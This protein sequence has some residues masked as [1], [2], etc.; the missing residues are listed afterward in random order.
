M[1]VELISFLDNCFCKAYKG[2]EIPIIRTFCRQFLKVCQKRL[3]ISG[4]LMFTFMSQYGYLV[5]KLHIINMSLLQ[6]YIY[7]F[8]NMI[9]CIKC[10]TLSRSVLTDQS[11]QLMLYLYA[12]RLGY[13]QLGIYS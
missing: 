7:N 4:T 8:K 10:S 1:I 2:C 9:T 5:M 3:K 11:A 12:L 6:K 13:L